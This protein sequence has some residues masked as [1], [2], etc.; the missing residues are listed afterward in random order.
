MAN[1]FKTI[2]NGLKT[3]LLS[4]WASGRVTERPTWSL[5]FYVTHNT[6]AALNGTACV[7]ARLSLRDGEDA[8]HS[9]TNSI[10]DPPPLPQI[11]ASVCPGLVVLETLSCCR[12]H[13]LSSATSIHVRGLQET[14]PRET[15]ELSARSPT[16]FLDMAVSIKWWLSLQHSFEDMEC[17]TAVS[18]LPFSLVSL[19]LS[20]VLPYHARL[21]P[22]VWF[23]LP[24]K[25]LWSQFR[26]ASR[27]CGLSGTVLFGFHLRA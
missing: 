24:H 13:H 6:C 19:Y 26:S 9:F 8:G 12:N 1:L 25:P 14:R 15:F 18:S 5:R 27:P 22:Y 4:R 23:S 17:L 10:P 20:K 21:D 3:G 11:D 2:L 7:W 16:L